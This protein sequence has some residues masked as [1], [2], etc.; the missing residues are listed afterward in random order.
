MTL[1]R[2]LFVDIT[3]AL[4]AALPLAA[5][6]HDT[7]FE[8]LPGP[9]GQ[10][11]L[12]LGTGNQY[13]VHDSGIDAQYLARQ[14]CRS[15]DPQAPTVALQAIRNLR[16]VLLLR[17]PPGAG[18]CWAQLTPFEVQ[19]APETV[20]VYFD[21]IRAPPAVR[22]AWAEMTQRGVVWRERYTKHARIEL[23]AT[24][25]SAAASPMDMDVL[26][27]AGAEPLHAGGPLVAQVLRDGVPLAGLSVEL[28][29]EKGAQSVWRQTDAEGRVQMTLPQ[30][31]RWV[32]RATDLRLSSTEP[33]RWE[34]RFVT[35]A[36]TVPLN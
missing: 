2:T 13:P 30:P 17:A 5:A 12:A 32:L 25:P 14:G 16:T 26:I 8:A 24:A 18:M 33:D 3:L 6:A 11:L 4:A 28:H 22:A 31:G 23:G 10:A 35:L 7:W 19:I 29:S 1:A 15:A 20:A 34:S 21:D 27:E 36:F 9:P